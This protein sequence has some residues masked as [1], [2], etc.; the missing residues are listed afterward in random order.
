MSALARAA[1]HLGH[2]VSGSDRTRDRGVRTPLLQAL[3]SEGARLFPQDGSGVTPETDALV[4]SSAIEADNPEWTAARRLDVAVRGRAELLA[5]FCRGSELVAVAGTAGKTTVTGM[6]GHIF[7]HLGRSPNVY[8]G[9]EML[10]ENGRR[11]GNFLPGSEPLWIVETDES[12]RSLLKFS[13]DHAVITNLGRDH[14]DLD[15]VRELFDRFA[16][17][18]RRTLVT[19]GAREAASIETRARGAGT[20]F[21][22]RGMEYT[23]PQ[24]GRHNVE[25][26]VNAILLCE[27]MGFAAESV[28]DA[29]ACFGGIARRLERVG[30]RNGLPVYDDYAHNPLKIRSAWRTLSERCG[31]V[32]GWWRPHGYGPLADLAGALEDTFAEVCRP[33]DRLLVLPVFYAGGTA[34]RRLKTDDFVKRLAARGVPAEF[35][36]SYEALHARIGELTGGPGAGDTILLGMGAR[37]PE[38]EMFAR[39]VAC[40]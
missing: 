31:R 8:C 19:D 22:W 38:L 27:A 9:G 2:A 35:A 25:N 26:A 5:D 32:V 28:R 30:T 12:D 37:D 13:P 40:V 20:A 3:E 6:L 17:A 1:L 39:R 33:D 18:T 16:A 7:R 14:F 21:T 24:P 11:L 23:L 15:E 29:L 10:A 4:I 34:R 36:G